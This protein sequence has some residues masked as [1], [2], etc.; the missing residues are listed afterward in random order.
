[1][2]DQ[3]HDQQH[4]S[5]F[6]ARVALMFMCFGPVAYSREELAQIDVSVSGEVELNSIFA[7]PLSFTERRIA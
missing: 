4:D 3:I 7:F 6:G 2:L 1:M 5:S